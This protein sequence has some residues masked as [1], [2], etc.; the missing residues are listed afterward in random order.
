MA[1]LKT[2]AFAGAAAELGVTIWEH[3]KIKENDPNAELN[4]WKLLI[5]ACAGMAGA[6]LPD[7]IE[8]AIHP[9]HRTTFHS[10]ASGGGGVY[11]V[12]R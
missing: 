2:H 11:L 8:P 5:N 12:K 3:R 4:I 9:N 1:N 7:K 10:L 6:I